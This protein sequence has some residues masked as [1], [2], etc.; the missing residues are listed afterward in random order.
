MNM[1]SQVPVEYMHL[2]CTGVVKKLLTAITEKYRK[3][4]KLSG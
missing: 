2:I 3:E 4:M 1:I